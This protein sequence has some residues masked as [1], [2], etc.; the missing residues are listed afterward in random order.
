M[1][2][3]NSC[4]CPWVCIGDFNFT[5]NDK[6]TLRGKRC[7]GS[8]ATNYLKELIFKFGAIDLGFSGN[9]FTWARGRWGSLAIKIRLD[10]GIVSISWRLAF[11]KA[12]VTHLGALNSNH[13]PILLNTNPEDSFAH[14][15]FRF[16]AAWIR[17]NGCNS[18]VEKAW[19]E[20]ARGPAFTKLYKK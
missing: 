13:T 10:R 20:E 4:Q 12:N 8:S 7:G 1:A 18:I 2:L 9:S 6:E 11:P 14:K 16:E 3:L 5:T 17:D 19:N 15:S